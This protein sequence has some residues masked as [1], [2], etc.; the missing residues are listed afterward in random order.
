M[1]LRDKL[2]ELFS[3]WTPGQASSPPQ[4]AANSPPSDASS[5]QSSGGNALS[6]IETSTAPLKALLQFSQSPSSY[7]EEFYTTNRPRPVRSLIRQTIPRPGLGMRRLHGDEKS[8]VTKERDASSLADEQ[9]LFPSYKQNSP[10]GVTIKPGQTTVKPKKLQGFGSLKPVDTL[11]G[12]ARDSGP[13]RAQRKQSYRGNKSPGFGTRTFQSDGIT[14]FD[15]PE[16][17][18]KRRRR[19]SLGAPLGKTI[20]ISD[21]DIMEQAAPDTSSLA[22]S[23]ARRSSVSS[24]TTGKGKRGMKGIIVD[25]FR[26]VERNVRIPR[27]SPSKKHHRWWVDDDREE[28]FTENAAKERRLSASKPTVEPGFEKSRNPRH[29]VLESVEIHGLNGTSENSTSKDHPPEP[30][31][32]RAFDLRESP[33]ELQGEATVRPAPTMINR[34]MQLPNDDSEVEEQPTSSGRQQLSP[35]DI[36]PT[37]FISAS[38]TNKKKPNKKPKQKKNHS[39]Y[40]TFKITYLRV[41]SLEQHVPKGET[42]DL[43]FDLEN[44][45]ISYPGRANT[46]VP[47]ALDRVIKVEQSKSAS[48]K[49]RFGLTRT[50]GTG[51]QMDIELL[52]PEAKREVCALFNKHGVKIVSRDDEYMEKVFTRK[53]KRLSDQQ[54]QEPSTMPESGAKKASPEPVTKPTVPKRMKLSDSLQDEHGNVVGQKHA[55]TASSPPKNAIPQECTSNTQPA[56]V[57]EPSIPD[58]SLFSP[59][60]RATRSMLRRAPPPTVVCDDE[61]EEDTPQPILKGKQKRW[62]KPLIYPRFGKK[63]AEVNAQ[64]VERLSDNEFLNDN[65][66]GF[67]I[68]FLQDHL[69]RCNKEAAK[70]VYFFN[71]YFFAT[72]T[73]SPKGRRAINYEGV[74]KWTRNVDIFSHDYIVVPINENAHWYVAIICNLPY[75]PGVSKDAA[76]DQPSDGDVSAQPDREV[77]EVQETPEPGEINNAQSGKE[78]VTRQSLASMNLSDEE[79]SKEPGS[80]VP[81][82]SGS[83]EANSESQT[84][85]QTSTGDSKGSGSKSTDTPRKSRKQKKPAGPKH[86]IR[87]PIII[88]FDSLN[89]ARSPTISILRDYLHAEAKSKRDVEIDK[90]MIKGMRAQ[91]IPLQSN[92]SDCGLYL[93]AYLEKFVQDPDQFVWKLLRREMSTEED[94]PEVRSGQLRTRLRK[95]LDRLYDEQAQ[96]SPENASEQ[97][98]MADMQPVSYLLTSPTIRWF[99]NPVN[100]SE[101]LPEES[102]GVPNEPAPEKSGGSKEELRPSVQESATNGED[103]QSAA[104]EPSAVDKPKHSEKAGDII[105]VPDSQEPVQMIPAS[106]VRKTVRKKEKEK[107]AQP[108]HAEV[109]DVTPKKQGAIPEDGTKASQPKASEA[110]SSV[111]EHPFEVEIQVKRTPPPSTSGESPK[112]SP[113]AGKRKHKSTKGM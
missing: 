86:D 67:Y 99:S 100:L 113:R 88:T 36:R 53:N 64:D 11:S 77:Q 1:P 22:G 66:I 20:S 3:R 73:N 6:P 63:K 55:E 48:R 79:G 46:Q 23:S 94:W 17:P 42:K 49:M 24:Q 37:S 90:T 18:L 81:T 40:Q 44:D 74:Q 106:P 87:Q 91:E 32:Y 80:Q 101:R 56:E 51:D 96:L 19:D 102:K 8:M 62:N 39:I 27:E 97:K 107:Q 58:S 57:T 72:L 34:A 5:D 110:E 28:Q 41:G 71:S 54:P 61:N 92:Y 29:E 76:Q 25:E 21:D 109:V 16:R 52:L 112:K 105:E 38:S 78:E 98:V 9:R 15:S 104:P 108:D 83:I 2:S 10:G 35:H 45:V 75:L 4:P 7:A 69:E 50:K 84:Q 13:V 65:L 70:R 68:R 43:V 14:D 30:R 47:V 60:T 59:S 31:P 12:R 85:A 82:E 93:L 26:E 103:P 95:F 111:K 33:D 89:L